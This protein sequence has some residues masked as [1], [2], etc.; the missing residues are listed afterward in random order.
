LNQ[1][2][3]V[4]ETNASANWTTQAKDGMGGTRTLITSLQDLDVAVTSP[5]QI[6]WKKSKIEIR[7]ARVELAITRF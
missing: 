3:L 6:I 5:T 1:Q 4:F 2:P 7:A